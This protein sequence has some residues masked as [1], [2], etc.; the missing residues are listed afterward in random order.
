LSLDLK[1]RY[2]KEKYGE[3]LEDIKVEVSN[4][5]LGF[6]GSFWREEKL[7]TINNGI[8]SL[9]SLMVFPLM[10]LSMNLPVVLLSSYVITICLLTLIS[11][12]AAI[13][14]ELTH[15]VIYKRSKR[16][17]IEIE[18]SLAEALCEYEA[19]NSPFVAKRAKY[20]SKILHFLLFFIFIFKEERERIRI[21][22]LIKFTEDQVGIIP[23]K[24]YRLKKLKFNFFKALL[25]L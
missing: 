4:L 16:L 10:I 20:A 24:L 6:P 25:N 13:L 1:K 23:E 5:K 3:D 21:Q 14:H 8:L 15:A 19:I 11:T 7:I 22:A 2:L 18:E 9:L 17:K 12:D